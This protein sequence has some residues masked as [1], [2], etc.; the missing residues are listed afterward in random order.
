MLNCVTE[1]CV[2]VFDIQVNLTVS[3]HLK[4]ASPVQ[5]FNPITPLGSMVWLRRR[6]ADPHEVRCLKW[7]SV[8]GENVK[9][10]VYNLRASVPYHYHKQVLGNVLGS[11]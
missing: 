11:P 9:T 7:D 8:R 4:G 1:S 10:V 6:P 2:D 5:S 3:E